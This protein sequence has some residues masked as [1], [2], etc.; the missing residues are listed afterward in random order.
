MNDHLIYNHLIKLIEVSFN[1]TFN[2]LWGQVGKNISNYKN[3]PRLIGEC[4]GKVSEI[5]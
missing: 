4:G 2:R 1:R 3:F 5:I